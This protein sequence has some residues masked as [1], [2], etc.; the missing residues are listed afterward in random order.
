MH[1]ISAINKPSIQYN[2]L[3]TSSCYFTDIGTS[4]GNGHS[5][6]SLDH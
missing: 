1:R 5:L 4:S 6:S 3:N 2:Y